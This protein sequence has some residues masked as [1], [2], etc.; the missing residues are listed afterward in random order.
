MS[1]IPKNLTRKSCAP[2]PDPSV[3]RVQGAPLQKS[4]LDFERSGTLARSIWL[5]GVLDLIDVLLE[6]G[7]APA[8]VEATMA[9][10]LAQ[11]HHLIDEHDRLVRAVYSVSYT[12]E[13]GAPS[14]VLSRS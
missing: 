4:L 3:F 9:S 8:A 14:G 12:P 13:V 2:N 5:N 10:L 7:D 11:L 6:R 1:A